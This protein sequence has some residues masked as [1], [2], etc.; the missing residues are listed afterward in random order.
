MTL[1]PSQQE[2]IR[3]ALRSKV[4]VSTAGFAGEAG[5][6]PGRQLASQTNGPVE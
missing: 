1:A 5:G 6:R 4:V 3:V 2:A